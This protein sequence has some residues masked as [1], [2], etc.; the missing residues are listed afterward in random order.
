MTVDD[1]FSQLNAHMIE[2]LMVHS[3]MSDYYNFIGLKGSAYCH[4][5]HFFVENSNHRKLSEYY[6]EHYNK[7]IYE[8]PFQNPEIIPENWYQYTRQNVDIATRQS[9]MEMGLEKWVNW[10]K[11]TKQLYENLYRELINLNEFAAADELMKYIKDV[12]DELATAEQELIEKKAIN[13]NISDIIVEQHEK[14]K[15]YKHKLKEI[16]L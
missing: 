3:K 6:T 5:Y 13:F 1:I 10:E 14:Y 16:Q 8:L 12:D 15:K 2:G 7:I 11:N 9:A 4:K